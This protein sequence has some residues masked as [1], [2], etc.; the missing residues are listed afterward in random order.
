MRI[1]NR[2]PPALHSLRQ[3]SKEAAVKTVNT[4]AAYTVLRSISKAV[5]GSI[6][7]TRTPEIE[8]NAAHPINII[9]M[10]NTGEIY[11]LIIHS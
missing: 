5:I 11:R 6:K 4:M 9:K 8:T 10:Y 3:I 1:K 7:P 2:R